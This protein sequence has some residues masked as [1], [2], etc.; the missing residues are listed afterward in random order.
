MSE[1][2]CVDCGKNKWKEFFHSKDFVHDKNTF[3]EIK[4][5]IN[6]LIDFFEGKEKELD[7]RINLMRDFIENNQMKLLFKGKL[8]KAMDAFSVLIEW[9]DCVKAQAKQLKEV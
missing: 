8:F 6:F 1:R 7:L 3:I 5:T 9:R 4:P 2:N